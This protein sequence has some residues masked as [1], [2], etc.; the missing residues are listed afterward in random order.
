[1][2]SQLW[3]ALVEFLEREMMDKDTLHALSRNE[4]WRENIPWNLGDIIRAMALDANVDVNTKFFINKVK[5][6]QKANGL[7]PDGILGPSTYKVVLSKLG[8]DE[9]PINKIVALTI[10]KESGGDYSAMN[11]NG[12]YRGLFDRTW[13]RRHGSKHP[14]SGKIMIGLSFG[15]IQFTQDGGSLG[16][17]IKALLAKNPEKFKRIVGPTW[18]ELLNVL[19]TPGPS[20]LSTGR[21]RGPRVKK[22][23]VKIGDGELEYRDIWEEPWVTIFRRIGQDSE[24]QEVQNDLSVKLYLKP[25]SKFLEEHGLVSEMSAAIGFDLAVHRG[26]GG[27]RTYIRNRIKN[28]EKE[29]LEEV[30]KSNERSRIIL[31]DD[32]LSFNRWEG[33]DIL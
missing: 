31:S 8:L 27:A 24:F 20:G 29:T 17:L 2:I 5:I 28:S 33:W 19:T 14:A 6:F 3:Q 7:I 11:R 22:V 1:M 13:E 15:I 25:I 12:E 26:V 10:A 16:D 9:G 18:Q 21:L 23:K 4:H 32:R 30:A